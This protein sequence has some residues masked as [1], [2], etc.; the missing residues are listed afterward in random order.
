MLLSVKEFV[1]IP[2]SMRGGHFKKTLGMKKKLELDL[3]QDLRH[4]TEEN[5][6]NQV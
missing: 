6:G 5:I 4:K 3:S 2:G 1:I